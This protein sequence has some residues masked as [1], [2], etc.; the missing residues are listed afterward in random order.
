M[1]LPGELHPVCDGDPIDITR[2]DLAGDP[3]ALIEIDERVDVRGPFPEE[4]LPVP[5]HDGTAVDGAS[6]L[7]ELELKITGTASRADGAREE[8][9]AAAAPALLVT[10][11]VPG[12]GRPERLRVRL[13][14]AR[15]GAGR[16]CHSVIPF[17][18]SRSHPRGECQA[19]PRCRARPPAARQRP[20]RW[21]HRAAAA[22]PR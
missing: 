9:S 19:V 1:I 5:A 18:G 4:R 22:R 11:L 15:Q 14:L 8:D 16:H 6:A 3:E 21:T 2:D 12:R 20:A 17:P 7:R 10:K 13:G